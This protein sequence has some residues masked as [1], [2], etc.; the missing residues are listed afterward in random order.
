ME[1]EREKERL[2]ERWKERERGE[3]ERDTHIHKH[4]HKTTC[5]CVPKPMPLLTL[6]LLPALQIRFLLDLFPDAQFIYIH[7]DPYRVFRSAMNMAGQ[8]HRYGGVILV[9]FWG[10]GNTFTHTFIPSHT[11]TRT[12]THTH[13][14]KR[15]CCSVCLHVPSCRQNVLVQLPGYPDQWTNCRVCAKPI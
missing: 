4:K 15:E 5:C 11:H 1:G 12:H 6:R 13:T 8:L 14:H 3:G 9:F 7:R 2:R 10:G